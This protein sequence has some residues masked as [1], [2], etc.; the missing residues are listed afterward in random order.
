MDDLH[1]LSRLLLTCPVLARHSARAIPQA[2]ACVHPL[3]D[4]ATPLLWSIPSAAVWC[5]GGQ[6][7]IVTTRLGWPVLLLAFM[8]HTLM[9]AVLRPLPCAAGGRLIHL[10]HLIINR[11][12]K[13]PYSLSVS[14]YLLTVRNRAAGPCG[15][16]ALL[17]NMLSFYFFFIYRDFVLSCFPSLCAQS[18]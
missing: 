7:A 14:L 10:P 13:G 6:R 18:I 12:R 3:T 8:P 9:Q 1:P 4:E 2:S 5:C 16:A 11:S 15:E 17:V